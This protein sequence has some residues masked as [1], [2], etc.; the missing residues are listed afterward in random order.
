MSKINP[1]QSN[2]P[3][4][5]HS[6]N[7][8]QSTH[9][10]NSTSMV[11]NHTSV[12]SHNEHSITSIQSHKYSIHEYSI[13][14]HSIHKHSIHKHSIHKHSIYKHLIHKH[15]IHYSYEHSITSIQSHNEHSIC[16]YSIHMSINIHTSINP[17]KR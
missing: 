15:L 1:P 3:T 6:F 4:C 17:H 10:L 8:E 12:Q 5:E 9:G 13:H 14:K 7:T 11:F 16:K 2:Q